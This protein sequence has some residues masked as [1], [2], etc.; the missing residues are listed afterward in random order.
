MPT[1]E[2]R[3]VI[4]Q[5]LRV[6]A[7]ENTVTATPSFNHVLFSALGGEPPSPPSMPTLGDLEAYDKALLYR[8]ADLIEPE[9][10]T[11]TFSVYQTGDEHFP[12]CS[13][14]GYEAARE[15]WEE[16]VSG[17]LYEKRF[18]PNCGSKEIRNAD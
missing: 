14:C 10:R 16:Y 9:E 6:L 8:L 7:D 5:I 17:M 13:V 15:E 1:N 3:R 4:A 12:T 11:C 2:E 18:C